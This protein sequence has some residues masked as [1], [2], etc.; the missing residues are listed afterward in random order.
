VAHDATDRGA[1]HRGAQVRSVAPEGSREAID[2]TKCCALFPAFHVP[3]ALVQASNSEW[4]YG[5]LCS[6]LL[7]CLCQCCVYNSRPATVSGAEGSREAQRDVVSCCSLCCVVLL[8]VVLCASALT[9][10]VLCYF[11]GQQH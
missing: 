9:V 6:V 5:M 1:G 11:A 2:I 4:R 10:L 3:T 8:S 7:R